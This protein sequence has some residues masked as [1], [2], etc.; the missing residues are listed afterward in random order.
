MGGLGFAFGDAKLRAKHDV[1]QIR[2]KDEFGKKKSNPQESLF[3]RDEK[4]EGREDDLREDVEGE[5]KGDGEKSREGENVDHIL[6]VDAG[7]PARRVAAEVL[8]R[9][10]RA[11]GSFMK[12]RVLPVP[13]P[14]EVRV[15]E[16]DYFVPFEAFEHSPILVRRALFFTPRLAQLNLGEVVAS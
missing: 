11:A 9:L 1:G 12:A 13:P 7:A 3:L 8:Q 15:P 10:D 2:G 14:A 4:K 5:P 16:H 6:A